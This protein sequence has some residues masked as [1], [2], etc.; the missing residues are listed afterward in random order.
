MS[1]F[2]AQLGHAVVAGQCLLLGVDRTCRSALA[3]S[4][5]DPS[6]TSAALNRLSIYTQPLFKEGISALR[7]DERGRQLRMNTERV[8]LLDEVRPKLIFARQL[9]SRNPREQRQVHIDQNTSLK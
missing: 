9:A 5:F 6:E 8:R 3:T 1:P 7:R 2:G 4:G